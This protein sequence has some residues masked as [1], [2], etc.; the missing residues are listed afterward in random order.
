MVSTF[1]FSHDGGWVVVSHCALP[2]SLM[3]QRTFHALIGHVG[4][5]FCEL[6]L[7]SWA[8]LSPEKGSREPCDEQLK[9]QGRHGHSLQPRRALT[10]KE[11]QMGSVGSPAGRRHRLLTRPGHGFSICIRNTLT[12]KKKKSTKMLWADSGAGGEGDNRHVSRDDTVP[13]EAFQRADV[14][15][16]AGWWGSWKMRL[17]AWFYYERCLGPLSGEDGDSE[18]SYL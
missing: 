18:T 8:V 15:M 1:H 6:D 4:G 10:G 13:D 3:M 5:L 12:I 16:D 9:V 17:K 14:L 2:W 7:L 11:E